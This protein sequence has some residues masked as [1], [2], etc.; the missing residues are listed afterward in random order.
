MLSSQSSTGDAKLY[1]GRP[2]ERR[3]T[4]SS[5][6]SFAISI[7]PS[8]RSSQ[9]VEPSSGIRKRTA[10]SSTYAAPS[11]TR[12]C[13]S[14]WHR[15]ILSS[16]NV[17][18]PSHSSPS[19]RSE[20]WICSAASAT[21]RPVSVFSI[22]RRNSPPSWRAKSQLKSAVR[23]LPMWRNPVGLGAM[24]TRTGI[25]LGYAAA[26]CDT[27]AVRITQ[28]ILAALRGGSRGRAPGGAEPGGLRDR[29][30]EAVGPCRAR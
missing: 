22:L 28:N 11:S 3:M 21:S 14:A 8:T 23:T 10:P 19:Q 25:R 27:R 2:S 20:L 4:T 9:A 13:A 30:E 7:G 1:V 5:I 12:R 15:S 26:C 6:V 24:R 29:A 18:S 17:T 16:W